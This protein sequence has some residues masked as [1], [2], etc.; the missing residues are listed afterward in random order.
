MGFSSLVDVAGAFMDKDSNRKQWGLNR[1]MQREFAQH[2]IR[3]KVADAKAAGLHPLA[4]LGASTTS[5]APM[6]VGD[7]LGS[8]LAGTG[9]DLMRAAMATQ[10]RDEREMVRQG[11]AAEVALRERQANAQIG[12]LEAQT[13]LANSQ[14][15]RLNFVGPP[16]PSVGGDRGSMDGVRTDAPE[17]APPGLWKVKPAEIQSG[18]PGAAGTLAGPP[19]PSE[20]V[21]DFRGY[22]VRIPNVDIDSLMEE[23]LGS[24]AIIA[25]LNPGLAGHVIEDMLKRTG[26]VQPWKR[27]P[28]PSLRRG[29][30]ASG[31]W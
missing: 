18:Q 1:D 4:A 17:H 29:G 24:A 7:N 28:A 9:Q 13:A 27:T 16:M 25:A 5:F 3:W 2:G 8:A 12:L 20:R 10:T 6:S 19:A 15:A 22:K 23:P 14:A 11:Q 30:G 31:S 21:I 26:I